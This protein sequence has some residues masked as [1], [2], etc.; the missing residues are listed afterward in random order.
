MYHS[1]ARKTSQTG[2]QGPTWCLHASHLKTGSF[3]ATE[4]SSMVPYAVQVAKSFAWNVKWWN[5]IQHNAGLVEAATVA[6]RKARD[7]LRPLSSMWVRPPAEAA[8]IGNGQTN[9]AM[10]LKEIA[11]EADKQAWKR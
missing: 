5:H 7:D 3:R 2:I 6:W 4:I 11:H 9:D 8:M 10:I 1:N